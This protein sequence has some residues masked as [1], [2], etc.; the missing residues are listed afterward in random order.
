[1]VTN[2]NQNMN[3]NT[4]IDDIYNELKKEL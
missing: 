4:N 1:M 2:T 3:Q